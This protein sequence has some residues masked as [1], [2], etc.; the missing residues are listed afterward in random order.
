MLIRVRHPGGTWRVE[1]EKHETLRGFGEKLCATHVPESEPLR[2]TARLSR[3]APGRDMLV[4]KP[5]ASLASLGLEHGSMVH[6]QAERV[7]DETPVVEDETKEKEDKTKEKA[8][9]ARKKVTKAP[10]EIAVPPPEAAAAETVLPPA[11]PDDEEAMAR[12]VAIAR[13]LDAAE[14]EPR[15]ADST[16]REQLVGTE[17]LD[18]LT[19][20]RLMAARDIEAARSSAAARSLLGGRSG[21]SRARRRRARELQDFALGTPVAAAAPEDDD[22][23]STPRPSPAVSHD[24]Y[25]DAALQAALFA[26]TTAA[27]ADLARALAISVDNDAPSSA[28]V[29]DD[30]A[31][32]EELDEALQS[33]LLRSGNDVLSASE[34]QAA[35]EADL[36]RALRLSAMDAAENG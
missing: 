36:E 34:R 10:P 4:A 25:D 16:V 18:D 22:V 21:G 11:S 5:D 27:D 8:V 31:P 20:A 13:A 26:S 23:E 3:D 29:V 15:A 28:A 2:V 1:V 6:L 24:D 7:D 12:A 17:E 14:N 35:E 32:P 30:A 9:A 33:A 19:L